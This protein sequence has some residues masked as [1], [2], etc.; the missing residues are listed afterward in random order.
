MVSALPVPVLWQREVCHV[1]KNTSLSF[2]YE[3]VRSGKV[4][5]RVRGPDTTGG[6][7]VGGTY[8]VHGLY[9]GQT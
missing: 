5:H 1:P 8:R 2:F 4:C 9:T 7:P 6:V 3:C